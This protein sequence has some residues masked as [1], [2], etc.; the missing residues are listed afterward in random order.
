M[1]RQAI[2]LFVATSAVLLAPAGAA[3]AE[4]EAAFPAVE[5][6]THDGT[7]VEV[8]PPPPW[9]GTVTADVVGG[10][11][12]SLVGGR[13]LEGYFTPGADMSGMPGAYAPPTPPFLPTPT[14]PAL[15][16]PTPPVTPSPGTAEQEREMMEGL[17]YNAVVCSHGTDNTTTSLLPPEDYT[18]PISRY[19]ETLFTT[20]QQACVPGTPAPVQTPRSLLAAIGVQGLVDSLVARPAVCPPPAVQPAKATQATPAGQDP[21]PASLLDAIGITGLLNSLGGGD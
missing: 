2:A 11:M 5:C 16:T 21:A 8:T 15:P 17:V 10:L 12:D 3:N 13:P 19:L 20:S 7:V 4:E 9:L 6:T 18:E 1:S 14:P